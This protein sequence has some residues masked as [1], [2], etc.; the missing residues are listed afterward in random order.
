L[1]EK[2]KCWQF[3]AISCL[4]KRIASDFSEM[5]TSKSDFL[6]RIRKR[7]LEKSNCWQF[8]G[9]ASLKWSIA[10]LKSRILA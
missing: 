9:I 2:P 1:L 3:L 4:Q 5:L 6:V 7:K 8:F 10:D